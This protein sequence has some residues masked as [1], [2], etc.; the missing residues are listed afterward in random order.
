M[1]RTAPGAGPRIREIPLSRLVLAPENKRRTPPDPRDDAQLKALI[2]AVGLLENLIV[3][4]DPGSGEPA[5]PDRRPGQAAHEPGGQAGAEDGRYAVVAGGRRLKA[6]QELAAEGAL[7]ADHP[8]PCQIRSGDVET[9][10]I[11]LAEN[12]GRCAMHPADQVVAFSELADAG[13]SV[14]A[15]ATRFGL[16]ER[17][18]EQRLRLGNAAPELL[19]AYRVPKARVLDIARAVFGLNWASARSKYKKPALAEAMEQAFAAGQPPVGVSAAMQAKA[20]AW[21]PPGFAAFDTGRTAG[22]EADAAAQ[23]EAGQAAGT[24]AAGPAGTPESVEPA[25]GTGTQPVD[26]PSAGNGHVPETGPSDGNATETGNGGVLPVDA[27]PADDAG[28]QRAEATPVGNGHAPEAAPEPEPSDTPTAKVGNGAAETVDPGPDADTGDTGEAD[29]GEADPDPAV[30]GGPDGI[31]A[32][33]PVNG[34]D[35]PPDPLEI[36]EFLRRVQ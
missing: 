28:T 23:A 15:I 4:T 27:G 31:A 19:D 33:A 22:D 8:V 25:A 9:A 35:A 32:T 13:R 14:S 7:D 30:A 24:A 16:S 18:V 2:A 20:H 5:S 36:P 17:L 11:S 6:L 3:R 34:R 12:V 1:N 26:V 29:F 21:V 10:E